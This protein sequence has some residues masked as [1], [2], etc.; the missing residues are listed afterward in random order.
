MDKALAKTMVINSVA[1]ATKFIVSFSLIVLLFNSTST[2]GI[3]VWNSSWQYRFKY[4]IDNSSLNN[5]LSDFPLHIDLSSAPASFWNNVASDGSDIRIIDS[6]DTTNLTV[7]AH[8]EGWD[9][10]NNKGHIW[11]KKTVSPKSQTDFI[12]IYYGN[13]NASSSWNKSQTYNTNYISVWHLDE[14]PADGETHYDATS[15]NSAIFYDSSGN[16]DT[17]VTGKIDGADELDG[18]TGYLIIANEANFDF[19]DTTFTIEGW[20]KTTQTT[21]GYIASKWTSGTGGWLIDINDITGNKLGASIKNG[22]SSVA[23]RASSSSINNGTWKHFAV[24]FTTNTAT[25][26]DNDIKIYING[27]LDQ[28]DLVTSLNSYIS[29]DSQLLL[30]RRSTGDY[31][32]GFLDEIRVSSIERS[33]EWIE[34]SY[35]SDSGSAVTAGEEED[36]SPMLTF[37][38][39]GTAARSVI[40]G[41]TTSEASTYSTLPFGNMTAGIP[42]YTAHQLSVTTNSS[43]GYTVTMQLGSYL[44]GNYL[45]NNIDPFTGSGATWASPQAWSSPEGVVANIN[46]GWIGANTSDTRVSG[47][48]NSAGKFG[49][50]STLSY[51][52]MYST[53]PD[54]SGTT[55]YVTYAIEV[56]IFQPAD[57]Y[58]GTIIYNIIPT[59]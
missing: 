17:N 43:W 15:N 24:V 6:N 4:T 41:I 32:S 37:T 8:L 39:A 38:I 52:V 53:G 26:E 14:S 46:T 3:A 56:N 57:L 44:Q 36:I 9:K 49:P 50:V 51:P 45:S 30:G 35:L 21:V 48:T 23:E 2:P 19:E 42:K 29:S 27:Q 20:L 16:S 1:F 47:W 5:T 11:V 59:Y 12:W 54:I 28:G 13:P 18:N 10:E 40:N 31:Y 25:P 22:S 55:V 33:G 58:A 34:F 7:S